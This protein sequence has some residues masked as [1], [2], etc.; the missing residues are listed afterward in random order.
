M[1][2]HLARRRWTAARDAHQPDR[3][4]DVARDTRRRLQVDWGAAAALRRVSRPARANGPGRHDAGQGAR[5]AGA[6]GTLQ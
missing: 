3:S 1:G 6:T 2:G 5:A 4:H